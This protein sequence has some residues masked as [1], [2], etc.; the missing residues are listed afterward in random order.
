[1]ETFSGDKLKIG[2]TKK[3]FAVNKEDSE[4]KEICNPS[5]S[6]PESSSS[7]VNQAYVSTSE[8]NIE[9][10]PNA[11]TSKNFSESSDRT[12]AKIDYS[13]KEFQ[14]DKYSKSI[15]IPVDRHSSGSRNLTQAR[16]SYSIDRKRSEPLE[17]DYLSRY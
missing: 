4:R 1:M 10:D 5:Q 13:S 9:E 17:R 14:R 3:C 15:N 6:E 16:S 8:S 7:T 2:E 12:I 11:E